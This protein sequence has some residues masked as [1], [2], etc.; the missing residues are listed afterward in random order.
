MRISLPLQ[1]WRVWWETRVRGGREESHGKLL[2]RV[3]CQYAHV[4]NA[5]KNWPIGGNE[6]I[7][8]RFVE[9]EYHGFIFTGPTVSWREYSVVGTN[10]LMRE[11]ANTHHVL[12]G[13]TTI[14][15]P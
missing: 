1:R 4:V 7:I 9:V 6:R 5:D 10:G 13:I 11:V 2:V 3:G 14:K 12:W 8:V 15:H